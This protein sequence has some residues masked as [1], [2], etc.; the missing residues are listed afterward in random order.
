MRANVIPKEG[1]NS[2]TAFGLMAYTNESLQTDDFDAEI[3]ASGLRTP[4]EIEAIWDYNMAGGGP[5]QRDRLW[6][7]TSYRHWGARERVAGMFR[8]LDPAAWFFNPRLGAAGN[9]D[10]N[11]PVSNE[12]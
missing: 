1:G 3:L 4:N 5:I 7:Y 8:M 10:L 2:F 11:Q 9:A 12:D 6:F